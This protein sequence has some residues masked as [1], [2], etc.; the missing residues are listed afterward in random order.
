MTDEAVGTQNICS[1]VCCYHS[2]H[3]HAVM[4]ASTLSF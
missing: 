2:H 1:S 4:L 3:E